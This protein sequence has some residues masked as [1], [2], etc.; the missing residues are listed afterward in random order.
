MQQSVA[1]FSNSAART[2]AITSPV[3]GQMTYLIDS[4]YYESFDGTNW[5][6]LAQSSGSGLIHIKTVT[7]SAVSGVDVD[8]VFSSTYKNYRVILDYD[9]SAAADILL[10]FRSVS[11][12]STVA[13]YFHNRIVYSGASGSTTMV[14]AANQTG[15]LLGSDKTSVAFDLYETQDGTQTSGVGVARKVTRVY[16]TVL[17]GTTETT[18]FTGLNLSIASGN[19]TGSIQVFGYKD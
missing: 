18:V 11:G 12:T 16:E 2:A 13:N 1:T 8:D 6:P 14:T 7:F 17:Y 9:R 19:I 5:V 15:I 3:E 4:D 10:R